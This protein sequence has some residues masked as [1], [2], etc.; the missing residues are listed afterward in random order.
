MEVPLELAR[1]PDASRMTLACLLEDVCE[2]FGTNAALRVS[3]QGGAI[4]RVLSYTDLRREAVRVARGLVGAGVGKGTHVALLMGNNPDWVLSA[5]AVGLVGGVLV[6]V[7]TFATPDERAFILRHSDAAVLLI[8]REL[9]GKD[10]VADLTATHPE[11][12]TGAAGRLRVPSL[13]CLR[14][15][16][17]L[18]ADERAGGAQ[19]WTELISAGKDVDPE[20]VEAM[21]AEV[22]PTDDGVLIYTSGTTAHPKGVL[23]M[24]RAAVIQSWRFGESM[25]LGED[26]LMLTAQPFFWTAGIT[27][28]LG[29]ALTSGA[30]LLLEEKFDAE[31]FLELVE[32][33]R[34]TTLN[35]WPHQEKAMAEHP[36]AATRDLGS[37]RHIEFSS[38]LAPLAGLEK[39]EWGTY[40][41]YGL[42]E[43]FTLSSS[44][45]ASAPAELRS[46]TSGRPL[47]GM[48]VKIVDP[49]TGEDLPEPG[50][51]G[52]IAVR[53]ATFMRGYYK[54]APELYLDDNGFFHTQ[55]GGHF[56]A[57]GYLHWSGRLSNLI[58][59]G[60]AN[61]SPLE[62]E[63]A[64]AD[65]DELRIAQAVGVPHPVLGEVIVLCVV[66]ATDAEV[67]DA[68]LHA[69]LAERLAVYKR[70][71]LILEF[72]ADDLAF[73]ANAKLQ[74]GEL[75]ER[76]IARLQGDG[77]TIQG[78]TSR[79]SP[80]A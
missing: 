1:Q 22:H 28:S 61:V 58:K 17:C 25:A 59:T 46:R 4:D 64:L 45:P 51:K 32:A 49:E 13:P 74:V 14:S 36:S 48:Q 30:T 40:G 41:S 10:L 34:V 7:N 54:V 18:G 26:D 38:P 35:A 78:V 8:Q 60:G 5:F 16:F 57:D 15:V 9:L 11:I 43:T 67:D 44:L 47:P 72:G 31:R 63:S 73:T 3:G 77:A 66:A 50:Q 33:C 75:K 53:G 56:D 39:D 76:A 70:P 12:A 27:M 29:A 20:L 6:P 55:D 71:K 79:P 62:I 65:R 80:G 37:L 69:V 23:H 52:E 68:A 21:A 24:Q 42:S 19:P 2:R